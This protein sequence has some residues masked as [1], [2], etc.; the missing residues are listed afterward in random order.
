[1]IRLTLYGRAECH[2]CE[3]MSAV[4][5]QVAREMPVELEHVDVDS[6]PALAA[7]YG[8]DVPVLC[9]NGRRA[10]KYRVE[11]PALRARL[12]REPA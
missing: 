2:L 1:M 4:V 11:A 7:A 6:D 5:E 8:A 12:A 3:E 10:F 9:V